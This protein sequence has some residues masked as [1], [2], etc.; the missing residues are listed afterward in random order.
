MPLGYITKKTRDKL[1]LRAAILRRLDKE[2]EPMLDA[3]FENARGIHQFVYRDDAGRFKVI[4]DPDE[5]RRCCE[6]GKALR[7]FTRLPN[8]SAMAYL[9]DQAIDQATRSTVM[10]G[11]DGGPVR[12]EF[13]WLK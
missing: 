7:I 1:A 12:H 3:Q 9:V 2:L 13:M 8:V 5:L 4:D 6:E 11:E 10:T